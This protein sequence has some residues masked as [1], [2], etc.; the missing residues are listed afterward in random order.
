VQHPRAEAHPHQA[1]VEVGA[2]RLLSEYRWQDVSQL[3]ALME[4]LER[5][6]T[7]LGLLSSALAQPGI[8]VRIGAENGDP[9]LQRLSLVAS[10]YGLPS[11]T[12]GAVSL[13]GPTRMDYATAVRA[14]RD[15]AAIL[16]RFVDDVYD[17][18]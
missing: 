6:V 8:Y 4:L 10:S 16:S 5:R 11:R 1:L 18:A 12:L 14:V 7:L 2:A 9:A 17:P 3:N 15:A 13:I